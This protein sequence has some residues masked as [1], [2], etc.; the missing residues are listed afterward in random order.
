MAPAMTPQERVTY[1]QILAQMLIADGVLA[2]EERTHLEKVMDS[3]QMPPEERDQVLK[4]VSL[5]SPIEE[6]VAALSADTK[7]RLLADAEKALHVDGKLTKS[8]QYYLERLRKL[9]Q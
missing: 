4:G 9:V 3:L 8:E 1:V 5:D 7:R 6:R 2:D